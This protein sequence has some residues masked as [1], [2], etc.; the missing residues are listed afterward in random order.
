MDL[1]ILV[2]FSHCTTEMLTNINRT[3]ANTTVDL[4]RSMI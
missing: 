3:L 2:M 4:L 1:C